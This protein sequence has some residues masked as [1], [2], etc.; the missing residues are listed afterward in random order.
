MATKSART[1]K[2]SGVLRPEEMDGFH[3]AEDL[4]GGFNLDE[5]WSHEQGVW[6]RVWNRV[7]LWKSMGLPIRSSECNA[8]IFELQTVTQD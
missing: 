5:N 1:L 4:G 2:T 7:R 6:N 8:S 3:L